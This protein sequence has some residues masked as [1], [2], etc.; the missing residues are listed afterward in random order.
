MLSARDAV[1]HVALG[2]DD[3][4]TKPFEFRELV[5]RLRAL[6]RSREHGDHLLRGVA[7]PL[8]QLGCRVGR[9]SM[10]VAIGVPRSTVTPT[11]QR[12][13]C[14]LRTMS[15]RTARALSPP[16]PAGNR[17]RNVTVISLR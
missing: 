12:R 8:A 14:D 7:L 17:I 9:Y 2:A 6:D 1:T 11:V 5:M 4:L 16:S 13:S 3:Y 10:T 15:G